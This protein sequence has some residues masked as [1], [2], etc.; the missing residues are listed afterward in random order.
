MQTIFL[1]LLS[2]L[3]V[4]AFFKSEHYPQHQTLQGMQITLVLYVKAC[5]HSLS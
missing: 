5:P 3:I 1:P 2:H 4:F